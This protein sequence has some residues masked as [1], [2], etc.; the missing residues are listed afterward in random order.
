MTH[1]AINCLSVHFH[2]ATQKL[3]KCKSESEKEGVIDEKQRVSKIKKTKHNER[4]Q[5]EKRKL[6]KMKD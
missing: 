4:E 2:R 1:I 6:T 3:G 5:E